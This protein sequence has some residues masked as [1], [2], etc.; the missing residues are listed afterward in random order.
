MKKQVLFWGDSPTISTGFATVTRNILTELEKTGEYQFTIIGISYLGDPY[1]V[2]KHPYCKFP[3]NALFPANY[4]GQDVYGRHRLLEFA[5]TGKFDVIY[6]INDTFIVQSFMKDLVAI[7]EKLEKKFKIIYY[8]PIDCPPKKEW[9]EDAVKL[10]DYPVV[11]TEYGKREVKR[12]EPSLASLRV[13][14][15]GT[16][17]TDFFPIIGQARDMLRKQI[18][19]PMS[20]KFIVLNVNR[21]QPRKDL[22][23]T[24]AAFA[25]FKKRVPDSYLYIL[26]AMNDVGGN[27]L[28][29]AEQYGLKHLADWSCPPPQIYNPNQGIPVEI[30]NQL[31]A[32]ADVVISTT[33]GEGWGL[34][35]TEAMQTKK[36]IVVPR[37]TSL[38][39]IVGEGEERGTL[40][41]C[42]D[43]DHTIALGPLDNNRVRPVVNV[44]AMA[45][46]IR[47][48]WQYPER[49]KKKAN[50][51]FEWVPS[52]ED[53][54]KDWLA[55]FEEATQETE[56][57]SAKTE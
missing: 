38:I 12:L 44:E 11:Y 42:G 35:V 22:N 4:G 39:E 18:F 41:E 56:G 34:S 23:R 21:N 13:I 31:Y 19:G 43:I 27:L 40:V 33:I 28:E 52:W 53:V 6:L 47:K 54:C 46:A 50:K 48:V 20:D 3:D 2:A 36:P 37:N 49:A 16:N 1:D 8:F 15:H 51:A 30:V 25:K 45:E 5:K 17:K 10:A 24:F 7:R 29:M 14:Y 57:T 32:T 9:V 26:A 55:L